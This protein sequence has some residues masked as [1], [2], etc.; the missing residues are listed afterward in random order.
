[1]SIFKKKSDKSDEK[2]N[3]SD[4][5]ADDVL[6]E[7][8]SLIDDVETETFEPEAVEAEMNAEP[9]HNIPAHEADVPDTS[10]ITDLEDEPFLTGSLGAFTPP[11]FETDIEV[12]AKAEDVTD[13]E[14]EFVTHPGDDLDLEVSRHRGNEDKVHRVDLSEMRLDV[15][16]INSDIESGEAL[17]QRAQQRVQSLMSYVER[18]EVDFSL[19]NRLEP[20]NRRLKSRK[21]ALE[22]EVETL[23]NR[24][25]VLF[26]NLEEHKLRVAETVEALDVA[27]AKLAKTSRA[28][29]DREIQVKSFEEKLARTTLDFE[30]AGTDLEVESRENKNLRDKIAEMSSNVQDANFEKLNLA[31]SIESLKIDCEDQRK[32]R[33]RLQEE[34]ADLR[35]NLSESEKQNNQMKNQLVA[36]HE[37]IKTFKTQ[38]E[39]NILS[40]DDRIIA[41]ESQVAALN[42]KLK[43]KE[44]IMESAARDVSSLRRERTAQELERQRLEKTIRDQS[45]KLGETQNELLRSKQDLNELDQR[46]KDV[47][48]ALHV[49]QQF[50]TPTRPAPTPDIHPRME[51]EVEP[52]YGVPIENRDD[53]P[54]SEIDDMLTEYRLG[55]RPQI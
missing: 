13:K 52:D 43:Q 38:Y 31:K 49:S 39:Y 40:R 20:E 41:L 51:D 1:M 32:S 17:Y 19:L 36:V 23:K 18:A 55:I 14:P 10:E 21:R 15:A 47:A 8:S 37:E 29:D 6:D 3:V 45:E 33:E 11:S 22:S 34:N 24:N 46:Y 28:L 9:E 30:R 27:N 25:S 2:Q 42:D 7:S 44:N 16:R 5:R 48:A 53:D 50:R 54:A 12:E 35:Y 26:S 4:D